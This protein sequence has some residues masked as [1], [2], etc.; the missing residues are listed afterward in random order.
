M[1]KRIDCIAFHEA[2]HAVAHIL[3]GIPFKYVT[4]KE[5]KEKDEYGQR[6]L[7]QVVLNDPVSHDDWEKYSILDPKD[8]DRFFKDDFIKLSGFI[9]E[10][11]YR[12]R[13][14]YKGSKGDLRQWVGASLNKLPDRLSSEYC[15]I[16]KYLNAS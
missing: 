6:A 7:G 13:S 8:F 5:D 16:A 10:M 2:G 1:S 12:R 9:A 4:I 3:A 14:D 11:I 15:Y